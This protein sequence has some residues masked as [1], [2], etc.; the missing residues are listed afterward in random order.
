VLSVHRVQDRFEF[1]PPKSLIQRLANQNTQIFG[2]SCGH[3][4]FGSFKHIL[5]PYWHGAVKPVKQQVPVLGSRGN[6]KPSP[7]F[8]GGARVAA[9]LRPS[10][11]NRADSSSVDL[12]GELYSVEAACSTED[13][14]ARIRADHSQQMFTSARAA[15]P[16]LT[17][18]QR[19]QAR[20]AAAQPAPKLCLL[21]ASAASRRGSRGGRGRNTAAEQA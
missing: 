5:I 10:S 9:T 2:A 8:P 20:Q 16:Q 6:G 7:L 11:R 13:D 15:P 4:R 1:L 19:Q 21:E 3:L 14:R 17:R 12:I 18:A